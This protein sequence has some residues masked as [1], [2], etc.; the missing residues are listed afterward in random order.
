MQV[1]TGQRGQATVEAIA[2]A[3]A[4]GLLLAAV[5]VW[6]GSTR[7]ADQLANAMIEAI[8]PADPA[9]IEA[10]PADLALVAAALGSRDGSSLRATRF[11]LGRRLSAATADAVLA[12][13][14]ARVAIAAM[15]EATAGRAYG[16]LSSP[17]ANPFAAVDE[18]NLDRE[19]PT[20]PPVVRRVTQAEA[21]RVLTGL[22]SHGFQVVPMLFSLAAVIPGER[23]VR[24]LGATDKLAH[25]TDQTIEGV[26]R[27]SVAATTISTATHLG[28]DGGIPPGLREDDIFVAWPAE[29]VFV[30]DGAPHASLCVSPPGR[31]ATG[32]LPLPAR[33]LHV[34]VLRRDQ[35]GLHPIAESLLVRAGRAEPNPCAH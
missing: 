34:V 8:A 20:G 33:Y 19:T 16:A 7:S 30:R 23:L 17:H 2:L 6:A 15:P 26:D 31:S 14:V 12:D 22:L 13:A 18:A 25:A 24:L 27:L 35:D 4:V 28:D 11:L 3:L 29:R 9:P 32:P 21:A 1:A 10:G 5:V